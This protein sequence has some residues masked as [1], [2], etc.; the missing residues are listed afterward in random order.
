[1]KYLLSLLSVL[2]FS[3]CFAIVPLIETEPTAT[4]EK[5]C[6]YCNYKLAE[7]ETEIIQK[8]KKI[9][10]SVKYYIKKL[11]DPKDTERTAAA[12]YLG[13]MGNKAIEAVPYLITALKDESK[14]VRRASAR[15]LGNIGEK[16]QQTIQ[17]LQYAAKDKD[18]WV[19]HTANNALK[20]IKS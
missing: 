10:S 3:S 12:S 15:A 20:K 18:P 6:H 9:N 14:Y 2:S 1:M 16:S 11:S 7:N 8:P 19:A 4:T 5:V 13:M 17:S